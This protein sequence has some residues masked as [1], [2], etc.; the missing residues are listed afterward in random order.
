MKALFNV[1]LFLFGS[2]MDGRYVVWIYIDSISVCSQIT[3]LVEQNNY[4][5]S[6]SSE[7]Q[8]QQAG[9]VWIHTWVNDTILH[10]TKTGTKRLSTAWWWA[11]EP[12]GPH[13]ITGVITGTGRFG[14]WMVVLNYNS[15][16][17]TGRTHSP[18]PHAQSWVASSG[19]FCSWMVVKLD[20]RVRG[21][22][23]SS[24]PVGQR[25]MEKWRRTHTYIYEICIVLL[26]S[27]YI[28][29]IV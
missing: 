23:N 5:S 8:R 4:N 1:W 15:V 25:T 28:H 16:H 19:E 26:R 9:T 12:L 6:S 11:Q 21:C 27:T 18:V 22:F 2:H 17:H 20:S 10:N 13:E 14:R 24:S 7:L 3:Y 29:V